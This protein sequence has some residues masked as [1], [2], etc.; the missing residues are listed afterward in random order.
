[1]ASTIPLSLLDLKERISNTFLEGNL[2]SFL[3]DSAHIVECVMDDLWT[4]L[5][6]SINFNLKRQE[7][8]PMKYVSLILVALIVGL[9]WFLIR[10]SDDLS[11]EQ[12]A[13][14][15]QV[16]SEYLIVYL[17]ETN[18]AATDVQDP[19]ITTQIVES[20]KKMQARFKLSYSV[21][22]EHNA[23]NKIARE[24]LFVLT[25]ENG[26]DWSAK[27]ERI[28]DSYVE[29]SDKDTL[30]I[31]LADAKQAGEDI[32]KAK[33]EIEKDLPKKDENAPAEKAAH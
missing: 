15:Q 12:H 26:Q 27:M 19:Q 25:S 18:P 23:V 17:K 1:L 16:I 7:R 11:A 5:E 13:R 28:N 2:S 3:S 30:T 31:S 24:G 9:S 8:N 20:G 29:F 4:V 6:I 10:P 22:G 14:L 32:E 21:P 33:K